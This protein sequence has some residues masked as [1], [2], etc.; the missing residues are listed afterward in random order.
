M[1]VSLLTNQKVAF[2]V[3]PLD[4][5]GNPSPA[6]L[7]NLAFTS[8]D[9]TV[10][11]VAADPNTPDGG[12]VTGVGVGSATLTATATAT[13]P[14]GSTTEQIQG[15]ATVVFGAVPPPPPAP[16]ASLG[17]TFGTPVDQ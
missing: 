16:A 12:V 11:T 10:F 7:S 15:V 14:D 6:T 5:N 1:Q 4:A 17:F 8:G 13:E 2:T 3:A 9:A